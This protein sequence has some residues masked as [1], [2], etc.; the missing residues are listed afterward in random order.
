MLVLRCHGHTDPALGNSLWSQAPPTHE[1]LQSRGGSMV[2]C[3]WHTKGPAHWLLA[4]GPCH[5]LALCQPDCQQCVFAM[6]MR[7]H[8]WDNGTKTRQLTACG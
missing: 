5:G 6:K 8:A 3:S 4:C 2:T 1:H 7:I